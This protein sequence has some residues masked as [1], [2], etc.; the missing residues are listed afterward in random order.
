[1]QCTKRQC[2]SRTFANGQANQGLGFAL[3]IVH[4]GLAVYATM[5]F[6]ETPGLVAGRRADLGWHH[7]RDV[8][9]TA[10]NASVPGLGV[11]P[12]DRG[13]EVGPDAAP[14]IVKDGPGIA[15]S[16][17]GEGVQKRRTGRASRRRAR[18][19]S[20]NHATGAEA[21]SPAPGA[22]PSCSLGVPSWRGC[23]REA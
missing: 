11:A 8:D 4:E 21:D 5:M 16:Q 23:A 19:S 6:P 18:G 10:V 17:L 12:A 22:S 9:E 1:M 15:V 20:R 2:R 3:T 7:G 13:P 14:D